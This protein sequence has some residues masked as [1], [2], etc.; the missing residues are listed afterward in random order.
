VTVT[1]APSCTACGA[2]LIT[3][4]DGALSP[5]PRRPSVRDEVCT[6]CLACIEVCPAG[7]V[8]FVAAV[9]DKGR[10]ND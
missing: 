1:I 5:A 9:G 3:C 8:S 6:D 4:P 10:I 7:A 2:C